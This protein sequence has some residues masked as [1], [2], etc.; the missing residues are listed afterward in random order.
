MD[1]LLLIDILLIERVTYLHF[2][3]EI[4]LIVGSTVKLN[5]L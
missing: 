2:N 4:S 3:E 1:K 5:P